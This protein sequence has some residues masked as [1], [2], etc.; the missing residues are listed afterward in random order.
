M[1]NRTM[2]RACANE[3]SV[4]L[5]TVSAKA[6]SPQWFYITYSEL[7]RLRRDG[8]ILTSDI[9]SFARIRLDERRD[10]ITF[11]FTWLS[12]RGSGQV[13]GTEQTVT[14]RWSGFK[15][16][17]EECRLPDGPKSY[18]AI[19]IDT[20]KSR[21][22]LVFDASCDNLREAIKERHI[23]HKLSKA[24]MANFNYPDTDEIRFYNDFVPYSFF[25]REIRNGQAGMCGGLILH[26]RDDRR[27]MA[28]A[29]HT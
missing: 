22:R 9:R 8:S 24:L 7:D 3:H 2:L 27:R 23:R 1:T 29:V 4:S 26:D 6:R 16:F 25:F 28:Y 12:G 20:S 15:A 21:P 11:E 17:L 13:E 5:R 10:R 14:L 19:S 18:K